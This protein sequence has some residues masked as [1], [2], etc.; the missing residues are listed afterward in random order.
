MIGITQDSSSLSDGD[1]VSLSLVGDNAVVTN[2]GDIRPL[3]HYSMGHNERSTD[4][5]TE[6]QSDAASF[7]TRLHRMVEFCSSQNL[8]HIISWELEGTV[9]QIH[10]PDQF[11]NNIL[12][13]FFGNAT[14]ES[15]LSVS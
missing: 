1:L 11:V 10:E 6:N 15:F 3:L 8:E 13:I 7:P 5:Q 12:P 4:P 2:V 14:L 9:F